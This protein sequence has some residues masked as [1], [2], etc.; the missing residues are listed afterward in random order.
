MDGN[1]DSGRV[2]D[3]V[4]TYVLEDGAFKFQTVSFTIEPA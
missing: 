1:I 4:D 3:G 2:N